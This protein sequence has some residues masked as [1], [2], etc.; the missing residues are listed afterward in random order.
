M[1]VFAN[2]SWAKTNVKLLGPVVPPYR[3]VE[4]KKIIEIFHKEV[5]DI[6]V[7]IEQASSWPDTETKIVIR[8]AAGGGGV[9]L[10]QIGETGAA[11]EFASRGMLENL[12]P[13]LEK[14][15]TLDLSMFFDAPMKAGQWM[16]KTYAIP[17][18]SMTTILYY[19]EDLLEK[20]GLEGAPQTFEELREYAIKMT[21]KEEKQWGFFIGAS[22]Q[23]LSEVLYPNGGSYMNEDN[24]MPTFNDDLGVE[25][26]QYYV[27][28][29]HK[30]ECQAPVG[31]DSNDLWIKGKMAMLI[32]VPWIVGYTANYGPDVKYITNIHPQGKVG[33]TGWGWAH[34]ISILSTSKNKEEAY[35]FMS[36]MF[37]G[38]IDTLYHDKLNFLPGKKSTWE[39]PPFSEHPAWIT[40]GKQLADTKPFPIFP[41]WREI[42][43]LLDTEMEAAFLAEKEPKQA[44]D[45]AAAKVKNLLGVE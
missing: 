4:F 1:L 40:F 20:A 21:N 31:T 14:D 8:Y 15:E 7:T 32:T 24:T 35:Q 16:G 25:A 10:L 17:Q 23:A 22:A 11:T 2:I 34:Y 13:Y 33:R 45:D 43:K 5:P 42:S 44:L 3:L 28:N 6:R 30:Y 41:G 27:D 12:D 18:D 9:D 37:R 29:I 36:F 19:N 26:L 38:E 39:K